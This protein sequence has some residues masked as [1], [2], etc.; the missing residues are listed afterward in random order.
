MKTI[1]E[2]IT[3]SNSNCYRVLSGSPIIKIIGYSKPRIR[4]FNNSEPVIETLD[5][6]KPRIR[7]FDNSKPVFVTFDNSEPV[8]RKENKK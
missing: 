4:T 1:T 5:D 6:S 2:N 7:T 8:I 3:I